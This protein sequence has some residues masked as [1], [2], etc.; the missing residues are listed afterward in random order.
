MSAHHCC[1]QI[2]LMEIA[3]WQI[4]VAKTFDGHSGLSVDLPALQRGYVWKFH[5]VEAL[6]DSILREMPIGSLLLAK[7]ESKN[8]TQAQGDTL[9]DYFLLDG[10]QRA[11]AIGLGFASPWLENMETPSENS[12][13]YSATPPLDLALWLDLAD[14]EPPDNDKA[15][16]FRLLTRSH[17]W[18]YSRRDNSRLSARD[19]NEALACF[20]RALEN[21]Q[22][23]FEQ[24]QY[25]NLP[26]RYTWPWDAVLP[27]PFPLLVL[28][29]SAIGGDKGKIGDILNNFLTRIDD[30][31]F[32]Q[33]SGPMLTKAGDC[34][35][36]KLSTVIRDK[37]N[38]YYNKL[39]LL[40]K[41]LVKVFNDS[42]I[43]VQYMP[44]E[45]FSQ[46]IRK[47][48]S[49]PDIMESLFFRVNTQGTIL[50]G[51][52]LIYSIFKSIFPECKKL[53][54][55]IGK[56]AHIRPSRLVALVSR[57][58]LAVQEEREGLKQLPNALN[59]A[60][61]RKKFVNQAEDGRKESNR[62]RLKEFIESQSNS[63]TKSA[64]A[65]FN[66]SSKLLVSEPEKSGLGSILAADLAQRTPDLY[67]LFLS[68]IHSGTL[69]CEELCNEET[70]QRILGILT[71]VAWF[72]PNPSEFVRRLWVTQLKW[73]QRSDTSS[74]F[75]RNIMELK[76]GYSLVMFPLPT[77][78][79]LETALQKILDSRQYGED[80]LRWGSAWQWAYDGCN[81]LDVQCPSESLFNKIVC[82][83]F[84][85][86]EKH[87]SDEPV[88]SSDDFNSRINEAW[89][90]FWGTVMW[91]KGYRR[92][93]LFAQRKFLEKTF[94]S[95]APEAPD[96]IEDSDRP[97]DW[98]HILPQ[99]YFG[100]KYSR[101]IWKYWG[102]S[103]GN[104]R[105]WPLADNRGD[106]DALPAVKLNRDNRDEILRN[107]AI[108]DPKPW[109]EIGNDSKNI[110]KCLKDGNNAGEIG[111][112]V[113]QAIVKRLAALYR[114]WYEELDLKST[115]GAEAASLE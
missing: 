86:T 101:G 16:K 109:L 24:Y 88:N 71:A 112:I 65:L 40:I 64:V 20:K 2:S 61:F 53:V 113:L 23:G 42:R 43:P 6:W 91:D 26:V 83:R 90:K 77:P 75:N 18:G 74:L 108:Y 9:P 46:T 68:A 85:S 58:I 73:W 38:P 60:E 63:P 89:Q 12:N 103:N 35:K 30:C 76:D 34:W 1:N 17:P 47:L 33:K 48:D 110:R 32:W 27:V 59:V 28:A 72:S 79:T 52:E 107:S 95:Y 102:Q 82:I 3:S 104:I 114:H 111:P 21:A 25:P 19:R 36:G 44:E 41:Q 37:Q 70:R 105:A 54:E 39:F 55:K 4:N 87:Q 57:L 94:S 98:D 10:Q 7:F 92:L 13:R 67:F 115:L 8:E 80:D 15:L 69:T 62:D 106:G 81:R 31:E 14:P 66:A 56:N 49:G 5:Q 96:Q 51:E 99:S 97:Y 78:D 93:V 45:D 84:W 22:L 50:E 29:V 11:T 100:E